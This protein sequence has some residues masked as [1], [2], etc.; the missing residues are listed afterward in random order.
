MHHYNQFFVAT[1]VALLQVT[2]ILYP[3]APEVSFVQWS[4]Y[5]LP[6]GF[7]LLF[8]MWFVFCYGSDWKISRERWIY[9]DAKHIDLDTSTFQR[10]LIELGSMT[11]EEWTVVFA[12]TIM[13]VLWYQEQQRCPPYRRHRPSSH[14][15]PSLSFRCR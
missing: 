10:Q 15:V 13:I 6:I 8:F 2:R 12:M 5:A 14:R 11:F 3:D 7:I 9:R 4:L 1:N